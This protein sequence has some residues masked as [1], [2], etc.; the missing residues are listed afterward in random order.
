MKRTLTALALISS[1]VLL[2]GC[3]GSSSTSTNVASNKVNISIPFKAVAGDQAIKCGTDITVLGNG[4]GGAG[5]TAKI[6]NFRMFVHDIQ[7]IT[8]QGIELPVTLDA[9]QDGQNAGVALLDFRDTADVN[10]EGL[11]TEICPQTNSDSTE[12]NPNYNDTIMGSVTIDPAYTISEIQ[13][14]LGVPFDLNHKDPAAAEEPLR[15]PGLAAG[16]RWNWQNGYKFLGFDVYP[17]GEILRPTDENWSSPKWNIHVGSTG[18]P[19]GTSDLNN[20]TEPKSCLAANRPIITLPLKSNYLKNLTIEIDYAKLVSM[21][22]LAKDSGFAPGCMSGAEDPECEN[23]FEKFGLSWGDKK[24]IEQ[25]V[26]SVIAAS[27]KQ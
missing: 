12:E 6:S 24:A 25:S 2:T 19:V 7:L 20:G 18:C 10:S 8:D 22:N 26:F 23:I 5:N 14:K 4:A 21:N 3:G 13:F 11:I 17:E 1:G 16:M 15:D 27:T 9:T